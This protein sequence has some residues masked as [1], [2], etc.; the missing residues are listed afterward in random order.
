MVFESLACESFTIAT[1]KPTFG[2]K[3]YTSTSSASIVI[4]QQYCAHFCFTATNAQR[5]LD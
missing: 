3:I 5:G 4:V 1:N 2:A